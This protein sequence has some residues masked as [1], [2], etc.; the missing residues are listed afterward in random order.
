MNSKQRIL[1][2]ALANVFLILL[3]LNCNQ[4]K[5]LLRA[6]SDYF[7]LQT[8]MVWYYV[9]GND[10]TTVE[11]IG[12]TIAL[13]YYCFVVNRNFVEEYWIKDKTEIRKLVEKETTLA[14][15]NSI[16]EQR[17]RRYFQLPLIKGNYWNEN[18]IDTVIVFGGNSIIFRHSIT[19]KVD[20]I[21]NI[22]AP[23][24]GF[25]EVYKL[26]LVDSV[27]YNDSLAIQTSYYWLAPEV[28]IVKQRFENTDTVEQVLIKFKSS[29]SPAP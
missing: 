27:K 28:G 2:L 25:F 17:F 14:G 20:A 9:N 22:T 19:G 15:H 11:V 16:L 12:D 23:A 21:E 5:T 29:T 13:G 26:A 24:G 10:T 1:P 3:I 6:T 7:P 8:G 18:F 4:D